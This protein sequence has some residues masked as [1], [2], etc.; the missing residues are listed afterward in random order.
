M[1]RRQASRVR[2]HAG[3]ITR[4]ALG[5]TVGLGIVVLMLQ[6]VDPVRV[7]RILRGARGD[8][9]VVGFV[10]VGAHY[11]AVGWRFATFCHLFGVDVEEGVLVRI[12]IVSSAINRAIGFAGLVVHTIRVGIVRLWGGRARDVIASA[13]FNQAFQALLTP[14]LAV[15]GLYLV[16]GTPGGPGLISPDGLLTILALGVV[17]ALTVLLLLGTPAGRWISLGVERL[18]RWME[19]G[20]IGPQVQDVHEVLVERVGA[21]RARPQLLARPGV[22]MVLEPATSLTL[23]FLAFWAIGAPQPPGHIILAYA[24]VGF[25]AMFTVVPGGLGIREGSMAGVLA[26]IGVPWETAVA[27]VVLYRAM[28]DWV[29]SLLMLPL[30]WGLLNPPA[31]VEPVEPAQDAGEPTANTGNPR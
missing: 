7:W 11:A 29:P 24:A 19:E 23:L 5:L 31:D 3:T 25:A 18:R 28:I 15:V 10:V 2:R 4:G 13:I 1:S 30:G 8:L 14:T 26:W 12:G 22:F 17:A 6:V 16:F 21:I 20:V 27:G 9:V